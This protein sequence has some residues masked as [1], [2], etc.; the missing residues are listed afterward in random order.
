M[1]VNSCGVKGGCAA[2]LSRWLKVMR[3]AAKN[4]L[5]PLAQS[6]AGAVLV[7][8]G[9]DNQ[10]HEIAAVEIGSDGHLMLLQGALIAAGA[11]QQDC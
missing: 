1:L 10:G 11:K 2:A 7:R 6:S 3:A 8:L 5:A 4:A 9:H